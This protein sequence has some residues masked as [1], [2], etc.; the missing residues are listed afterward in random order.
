M[1]GD[2]LLHNIKKNKLIHGDHILEN[3]QISWIFFFMGK[4]REKSQNNENAENVLE[5]LSFLSVKNSGSQL[6]AYF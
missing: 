3:P 1:H 5:F 4:I 6:A 2:I